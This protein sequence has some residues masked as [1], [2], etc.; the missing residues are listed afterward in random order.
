MDPV[1]FGYRIAVL[2]N[3]YGGPAYRQLELDNGI[4]ESEASVVFFLGRRDGSLAQEI[5][6]TI[7]RPKNSISR[8]VHLLLAKKLLRRVD[9]KSDRRQKKL[10]LTDSGWGAYRKIVPM[11]LAR[12]SE[13]ISILSGPELAFLDAVLAKMVDH[14][15]DWA[16]GY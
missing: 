16:K 9:G 4:T 7:G 8:A 5:A 2:R 6:D 12:E 11:F 13:L 10:Y 1:K 14:L 3:W 15:P